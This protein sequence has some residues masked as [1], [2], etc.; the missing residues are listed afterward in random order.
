MF[1]FLGLP[2]WFLFI[3]KFLS[4]SLCLLKF[5][6]VFFQN[7]LKLWLIVRFRLDQFLNQSSIFVVLIDW[8]HSLSNKSVRVFSHAE[9]YYFHCFQE[10][11]VLLVLY[12]NISFPFFIDVTWPWISRWSCQQFGHFFSF[13]HTFSMW[14]GSFSCTCQSSCE[15]FPMMSIFLAFEASQ[16]CWDIFSTPLGTAADIHSFRNI[17]LIKCQDVGV[18]FDFSPPFLI[19]ILLM[20]IKPC[21]PRDAVISSVVAS[22][23]SLMLITPLE[24]FSLSWGY[25]LHLVVWE[26]F[27]LRRSISTSK[28]LFRKFLYVLGSS[29]R[30]WPFL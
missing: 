3:C 24:V 13:E 8:I 19:V 5:G 30:R 29:L 4:L 22:A 7:L 10:A 11:Y 17:G 16:E 12:C 9:L 28:F 25:A 23:S 20:S 14:S 26:L 15:I 21:F 1:F 2:R 18:G 6:H 27:I